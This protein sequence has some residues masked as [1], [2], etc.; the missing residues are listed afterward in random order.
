MSDELSPL[1]QL[2]AGQD[3]GAPADT[4]DPR[5]HAWDEVLRACEKGRRLDGTLRR[6]EQG[7]WSVD[8]QGVLGYLADSA[9]VDPQC[10]ERAKHWQAG[11]VV[12]VQVLKFDRATG[13]LELWIRRS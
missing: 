5:Q 11:H 1:E 2:F 10:T 8:I 12:R 4:K 9:I 13:M 7:G 3:D 6:R